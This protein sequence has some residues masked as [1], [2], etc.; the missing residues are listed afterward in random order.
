MQEDLRISIGIPVHNEEAVVD[1]LLSRLGAVLSRQ[2]GGPHE[3]VFVDDGST[4]RTVELL[5]DAKVDN[6]AVVVVRLSRNFGHQAA[7]T[8]ALDHVTGDVAVLMDGDLQDAPE[9]IPSMLEKHAQGYDVVFA[10]RASRHEAWYL[11][12][13]YG[14]FYRLIQRLAD[15]KLPL[16]SGDFSLLSRKVI[17]TLK[18]APER[19]RYLRGLRSWAG[20]RQIG[21]AV[22]RDTRFGGVSK[23]SALKLLNLAFDGIFSFSIV[24]LRAASILGALVTAG[25]GVYALYALM[26]KLLTDQSPLG[27]TALIVII[28]FM[29]GVQLFFL[30]II[31]E[32]VGRAYDEA[33]ARPHYVVDEII[34]GS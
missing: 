30:G 5:R 34:R 2:R 18:R 23:Y 1:E 26:V 3:I 17:D 25:A 33:K 6:A 7:L 29:S 21:V 22:P 24:P 4:D 19:H 11:R 16:D 9:A 13:S 14:V 28:V 10:Q 15:V 31:G 12:F 27:F 32:Y 20:F 8:A